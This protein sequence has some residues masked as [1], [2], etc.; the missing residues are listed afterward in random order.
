MWALRQAGWSTWDLLVSF[1][2]VVIEIYVNI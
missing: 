2:V 1:V